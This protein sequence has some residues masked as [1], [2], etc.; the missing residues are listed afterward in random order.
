MLRD[1]V[2]DAIAYAEKRRVACLRA[3]GGGTLAWRAC[4]Q[5]PS[6]LLEYLKEHK[7]VTTPVK[8]EFAL[9]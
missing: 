8:C 6:G 7:R 2:A 3:D 4:T 5:L 9:K 1:F